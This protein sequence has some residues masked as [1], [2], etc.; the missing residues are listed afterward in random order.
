M[1]RRPIARGTE[2]MIFRVGNCTYNV[3]VQDHVTQVGC[4][5]DEYPALEDV[6]WRVRDNGWTEYMEET[7]EDGRCLR[8]ADNQRCVRLRE[9]PE[10]P[11]A[12]LGIKKEAA[13]RM[14]QEMTNKN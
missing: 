9:I 11:L 4:V 7:I 5:Y 13:I 14:I 2:E 3:E 1:M 6:Y 12:L 8:P 10:I